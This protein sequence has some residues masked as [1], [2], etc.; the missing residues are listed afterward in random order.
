MTPLRQR[1][2]EDM[3]IRNLAPSTQTS[4]LRHV[5]KFAQYFGKSPEILG[6]DEIR[7]YQ[8]Y[9][10]NGRGVRPQALIPILA[11]L[12]FLYKQT[13]GRPETVD[14]FPMPKVAKRL[15][16]VLSREEIA[17]CIAATRSLKHRALLM[18]YYGCGLRSAEALQ[19]RVEDIDSDQMIIRVVHGKGNRER[20]VP[21]PQPLLDVLREYWKQDRPTHWL[22]PGKIEGRTMRRESV[23]FFCQKI[24]RELNLKKPLNP[25][26]LRHS[27]ATHL[28]DDGAD[29]RLI[30]TLLG[31]RSLGTTAIYTHVSNRRIHATQSPLVSLPD[32]ASS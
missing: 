7:E 12:R 30:Q 29:L 5:T 15:P 8:L 22:F 25:H 13:L 6:T 2:I 27:F 18:I 17:A 31:H 20:I 11:A 1:M 16:V 9:M 14:V 28:L 26:S 23:F 32:V 4:Y 19:L 24:R 21:L 10:L 3:Q